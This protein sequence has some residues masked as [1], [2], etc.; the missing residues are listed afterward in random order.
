M[1]PAPSD[2]I[3]PL[4]VRRLHDDDA[5]EVSHLVCRNF[6]EVNIKD[7]SRE[8]MV[9]LAES[10]SADKIRSIARFAH[11]YVACLDERIVGC[12]SIAS[13]WGNEKE[14]ILLTIFVLPEFQGRGVGKA[15]IE[16]L[17]Q[18]DF[19]LRANRIE[20]PSSITACEFY[21][22]L[23]YDYKNGVKALDEE[24]LYRLEKF[25]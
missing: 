5:P 13:F 22:K 7:Y 12:G 9:R 25:R 2:V 17:E 10:Y 1:K 18:D 4:Q 23:G 14:S 21:R 20:I 16:T 3:A 6:M 11:S 8:E 24:G 19:F 15:I